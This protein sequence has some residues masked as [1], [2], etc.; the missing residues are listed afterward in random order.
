[1]PVRSTVS[2]K[3]IMVER[4]ARYKASAVS[5]L[6]LTAEKGG[7]GLTSVRDSMEESTIHTWAYLCTRV[8]LR[9][10]YN[11]FDKMAN[12]SKRSVISDARHV[13]KAYNIEVEMDTT[14]STVTIGEVKYDKATTLARHVVELMRNANDNKLYE[15][16]K[17][18]VLAGR[19][20]R[21][22]QAVDLRVSFEWLRKGQISSTGVRNDL[23]V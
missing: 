9:S 4:K 15:E 1:M 10:V 3:R 6:Y 14:T 19:V 13:L 11:L 5:R 17:E 22:K 2:L 8:D 16:W 23:A 12:R 21:S 20:L 7:Y 18:L